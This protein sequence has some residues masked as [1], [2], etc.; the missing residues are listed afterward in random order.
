MRVV[1]FL[2][3]I[4]FLSVWEKLG[5]LKGVGFC[6]LMGVALSI[7]SAVGVLTKSAAGLRFIEREK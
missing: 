7:A 4:C 1:S 5:G 2:L 3:C 6:R